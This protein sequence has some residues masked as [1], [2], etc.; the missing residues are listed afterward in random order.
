[1][2]F[3]FLPDGFFPL[4]PQREIGGGEGF[5]RIPKVFDLE[6][7]KNAS[8]FFDFNF[9]PD[10]FFP[11]IPQREIGGGEGFWRIPKIREARE[12]RTRRNSSEFLRIPFPDHPAPF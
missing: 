3:Y 6:D 5:W 1:L 12:S 2:N 11:I 4:I 10:G 7:E 8:A 9:F